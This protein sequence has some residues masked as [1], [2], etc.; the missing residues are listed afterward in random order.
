MKLLDHIPEA[1]L[2]PALTCNSKVEAIERLLAALVATGAVVHD[3]RILTEVL[4]REEE[5]VTAIGGGLAVPHARLA[6][7]ARLQIAV[8]TLARPLDVPA[9]DDEPV[10]VIFLILA[11]LAEPRTMLRVLARLARL[12]KGGE[13]LPR[14][15]RAGSPAEMAGAI[16]AAEAARD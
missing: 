1:G 11:P 4:R 9:E 10:D 16:A 6:G 13:L 5:G 2:L 7:V 3:A 14:L 15:R 8:A 12:V